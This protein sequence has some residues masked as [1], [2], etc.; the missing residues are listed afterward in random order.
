LHCVI[1]R[2]IVQLLQ[3]I[4]IYVR[5]I[6]NNIVH[7]YLDLVNSVLFFFIITLDSFSPLVYLTLIVCTCFCYV[8]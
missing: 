2:D 8:Y 3:I 5:Y 1:Y 7:F 4:V 6:V